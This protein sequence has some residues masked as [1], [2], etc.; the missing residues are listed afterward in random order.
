MVVLNKMS[1]FHLCMEA[2]RRSGYSQAGPLIGWCQEMLARHQTYTRAHFEDM[3][4]VRE[5]IWT[6]M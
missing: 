2:V 5:W 4:E 1:R 3:P 6:E